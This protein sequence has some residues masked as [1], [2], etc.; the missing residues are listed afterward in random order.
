M[1]NKKTILLIVSLV[2][3]LLAASFAYNSLSRG[4]EIDLNEIKQSNEQKEKVMLPDFSL[5][6]IEGNEVS[7]LDLLGKPTI[8][9]FWATWCGYCMKEMPDFQT[10]YE[11]YGDKINFVMI[12]AVD[13]KEETEEKGRAYIEENKYTFPVY[14][15]TQ[16]E[17]V[18]NCGVRGFP[19]TLFVSSTGEVLLGLSSY[20]SK[21]QIVEMAASMIGE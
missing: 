1:K 12:Q 16:G 6:D 18:I 4:N 9:N 3:I 19:T 5:V 8:I 11:T 15:D 10:V 14:F 2:V 21:E 13:G 17:A 20:L 7:S